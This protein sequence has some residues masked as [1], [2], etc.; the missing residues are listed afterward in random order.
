MGRDCLI[1][2]Y[3]WAQV[4]A[5]SMLALLQ[6]RLCYGER[7]LMV[8]FHTLSTISEILPVYMLFE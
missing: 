4:D 3:T 8:Q 6:K 2:K 7:A 1:C 5:N